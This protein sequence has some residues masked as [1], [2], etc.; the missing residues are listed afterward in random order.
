MMLGREIRLPIDLALGIPETTESKRDTDNAYELEKH[1]IKIHDVARKH[2]QISSDGMKYHFDK[3]KHFNEYSVGDAVWFHNPIRKKS[4]TLKLQRAWKG[5]Y[6]VTGK[7]SDVVYK[8][9]ESPK[10]K[11]KVVHHDR[12]KPYCGENTPTWFKM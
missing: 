8:I 2:I 9:Q 3:K 12:L 4:V 6:V 10:S 5:P 11:P 1:M 7:F